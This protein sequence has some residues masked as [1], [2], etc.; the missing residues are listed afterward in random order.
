[1]NLNDLAYECNE[2]SRSKGWLQE[3]RTFGDLIALM[4]SE[5]SEAL[6]WYRDGHEVNEVFLIDDKP[7]GVPV[8]L[9]D[10]LIRILQAC[11]NLGIDIE[12]AYQQKMAYN[13]TRAHRHG[14]KL[15]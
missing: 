1:M 5:L 3:T 4:H 6:E 7:E 14:G 15:I 11:G 12:T 13:K 10:C 9:A 8:E 2:V